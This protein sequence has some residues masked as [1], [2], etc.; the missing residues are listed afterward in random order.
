VSPE[1]RR[2]YKRLLAAVHFGIVIRVDEKPEVHFGCTFG[3]WESCAKVDFEESSL[4]KENRSNIGKCEPAGSVLFLGRGSFRRRLQAFLSISRRCQKRGFSHKRSLWP[5][6][7]PKIPAFPQKGS[8]MLVL[9]PAYFSNTRKVYSYL[10]L[11]DLR[12]DTTFVKSLR[13]SGKK[14]SPSSMCVCTSVR[15]NRSASFKASSY[16]C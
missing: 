11:W 15:C 5:I 12:S 8:L 1:I 16:T 2:S 13:Q 10:A 3:P 7:S 14:V 6:R 9:L 4:T